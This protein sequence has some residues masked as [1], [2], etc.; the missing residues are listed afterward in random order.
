MTYKF[1]RA[2]IPQQGM[3]Y[4]EYK[5]KFIEEVNSTGVEKLVESE[6]E[7]F[8]YKKLNLV[9]SGR[10]DKSYYVS[11]ELAAEIQNIKE[12]QLW[13]ILTETWCGDSAQNL[14]YISKMTEKNTNIDL[15]I[16]LRDSNP[17]I[18]DLYLTNGARSIPKLVAFDAEGNELFTWGPRPKAAHELIKQW[19]S[20]GIVKP[21]LYEKLHL[22][23]GR[24]RGKDIEAEFTELLSKVE[25]E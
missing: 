6:K 9:R 21:E 1:F 15:R 10:I 13:M 16:I 12:K 4:K 17:E 19:K 8:E 24:N 22:W 23:Y 11:A 3:T 18:M 5:Q 2:E 20:E 14:P 25:Q 7:L